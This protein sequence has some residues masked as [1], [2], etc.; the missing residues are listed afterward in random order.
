[1]IILPDSQVGRQKL[2]LRGIYYI[3]LLLYY[4]L[5]YK[6]KPTKE[7]ILFTVISCSGL[8]LFRYN[9]TTI[10]LAFYL[11]SNLVYVKKLD[12]YKKN[13]FDL[14]IF[15]FFICTVFSTYTS[16]S[17]NGSNSVFG[18]FYFLTGLLVYVYIKYLP[19][20]EEEFRLIEYNLLSYFITILLFSIFIVI[21]HFSDNL[22]PNFRLNIAGFH[23]SNIGSIITVNLPILI[24]IYL[25]YSNK[26]F[27]HIL[28]IV[29]SLFV[30]YF[31][32]SR[33]SVIGTSFGFIILIYFY[34][35]RKGNA[36][37]I[38]L[39][40]LVLLIFAFFFLTRKYSQIDIF[41]TSSFTIR[42]LIWKA[43]LERVLNHSIL[44]GFGANNEFF[45]TFLPIHYLNSETL[46][47][48][49][50]YLYNFKSNPH[51]HSLY[52]QIL[53]NYGVIGFTIFSLIFVNF[54]IHL[55]KRRNK[56]FEITEILAIV[57]FLSI[58]IQEF[59]DYT[60]LDAM[61]FYPVM[62]SLAILSR[63]SI[64]KS[65]FDKNQYISA[66]KAKLGFVIIF[67]LL[68]FLSLIS[69]NMILF[70]KVKIIFK[71]SYIIDNFSNI[72]ITNPSVF[73]NENFIEFE[74]L[75]KNYI[76][77][78]IDDKKEQFTAE[79]YIN[80]Y[81]L[82]NDKYLLDMAER[83]YQKCIQIFPNSAVCY[84]KLEEIQLIKNNTT[85]A[86]IY[87]KKYIDNDPFNLVK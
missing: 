27:Y 7:L 66:I 55:Y 37:K 6:L 84:K 46:T 49:K 32:H 80:Y 52:V 8:F 24:G 79:I 1:M 25:F 78:N 57:S 29:L 26:K 58:T 87:H 76:P 60:I 83:N 68:L 18:F 72:S 73:T 34:I 56:E 75:D 63:N 82:K 19:N 67:I 86:E 62:I 12:L 10:V 81:K 51:A 85:Q 40:I 2:Y 17:Y 71:N 43:Y 44:F 23:I 64:D 69:F 38:I 30:L 70:E 31:S 77:I 13:Y 45:Q 61:T 21:Y 47:E 48:L 22:T 11:L 59:F 5:I 15:L 74:K 41:N 16:F 39:P 42:M 36:K 53:Y 4:Y 35:K 50:D 3:T 33:S 14:L 28:F 54:F 65:E 20:K 9:Y